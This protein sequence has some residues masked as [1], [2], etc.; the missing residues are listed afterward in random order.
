MVYGWCPGPPGTLSPARELVF[1]IT[2][3]CGQAIVCVLVPNTCRILLCLLLPSP[4][5]LFLVDRWVQHFRG[6]GKASAT[7]KKLTKLGV[8]E[9]QDLAVLLPLESRSL[10][11]LSAT[12]KKAGA[13]IQA[14]LLAQHDVL[15]V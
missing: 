2:A 8:M 11:G 13:A 3:Q 6:S 14:E 12:K 9:P 10:L 7:S 4:L 5:P 1:D 15:Q